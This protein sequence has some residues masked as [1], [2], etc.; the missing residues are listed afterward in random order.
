MSASFE[1]YIFEKKRE[2]IKICPESKKKKKWHNEAKKN[3]SKRSKIR[4]YIFLKGT[5]VRRQCLKINKIKLCSADLR[6]T[7]K[8]LLNRTGSSISAII[9]RSFKTQCSL[10]SY[11]RSPETYKL[12]RYFP[13]ISEKNNLY[14]NL[15]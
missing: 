2:K 10:S 4:N 3:S 1:S 14:R 11:R 6:Q 9:P 13:K 15:S 5:E 7:L 8:F 12:T